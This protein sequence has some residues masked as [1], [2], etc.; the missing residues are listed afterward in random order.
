MTLDLTPWQHDHVF[1]RGNPLGER[2]TWIVAAMTAVMMVVEIVAVIVYGAQAVEADGWH[3]GTHVVAFGVTALS[4]FLARRYANDRRFAFGTWKIEVLGGFAS[5]IVLGI[6]ALF[7]I[8]DSIK[9]LL[10]PHKIQY[11]EALLVAVVGLV[12][13]LFC[14]WMLSGHHHHHHG[15]IAHEE[16]HEHTDHDHA[17]HEH[18]PGHRPDL[19]L[20]AAYIHVLADALTSVTAIFALFGGKL[21]G[22]AWLDP[23]MGIVGAAVVGTWSVTLLRDTSRI[24]L[25]REMDHELVAEIRESIE[26]DGVSHIADVHVWRVGR[27]LFSCLVTIVSR[28]PRPLSEYRE[29]LKGHSEIAHLT[30]EIIEAGTAEVGKA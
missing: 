24:L 4:Y 11:E 5:A 28:Q 17:G 23:V 22:W 16:D 9:V 18:S 27:V 6:V 14:A 10:S 3:M 21:F 20:R 29:R 30:I 12:V 7:I 2:N 8:G 15:P 26:A 25:D 1:D 13:N 19:N